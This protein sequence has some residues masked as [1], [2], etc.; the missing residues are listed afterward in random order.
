MKTPVWKSVSC[1]KAQR[2]MPDVC[3]PMRPVQKLITPLVLV[4]PLLVAMPLSGQAREE[5]AQEARS[6]RDGMHRPSMV[7]LGVVAVPE[8]SGADSYRVLPVPFFDVSV[9]E[10]LNV[11]LIQGVRLDLSPA[12][13]TRWRAGPLLRYLPGRA[14][15]GVLRPLREQ[16][17]GLAAGGFVAYQA[18][19]VRLGAEL[20]TPVSGDIHGAR[21]SVSAMMMG[22][23]GA[24]SFYTLGP[25]LI[26]HGDNRA[27]RL[28]G[29]DEAEA[30]TLGLSAFHA[31]AGVD[32]VRFMGSV[33]RALDQRW[34]LT[35]FAGVGW[36]V[37]DAADSPLVRDAGRRE[38]GVVGFGLMYRLGGAQG[39]P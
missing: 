26:W 8:Y 17:G 7:G 19:P 11:G 14:D 24:R 34:V 9:G 2:M 3:W 33:T 5:A 23:L 38:Q 28:Y 6:Q 36:L 30:N 32:S 15:R 39:A 4:L 18:G 27:N 31:D 35:G 25:T 22:R 13:A 1:R 37:G 12:T 29:L 20:E 16:R 10:R 21:A